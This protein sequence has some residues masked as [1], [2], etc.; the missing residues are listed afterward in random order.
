MPAR[1]TILAILSFM[2]TTQAVAPPGHIM[3]IFPAC[4]SNGV[5]DAVVKLVTDYQT[6]A[7]ATCAGGKK[8][9]FVSSNG[10][11]YTLPVSYPVT[12]G[13]TSKCKFVKAKDAL[14]FTVQVIVGYGAP[15]NRIHQY[16]EHY[17]ISCSFQPAANKKSGSVTVSPGINPA[18]VIPGNSPPRSKSIIHLY[19]VDVIGR[20]LGSA[21]P[22]GK[23]VRLQAVT[24]GLKDKGIRPESCDA[25][26]SKGGRFPVLRSGCGE[27]MVIKRTKGFLTVGKKTYSSFFKLFI[28]NGDPFLSFVCNFTVCDTTCNGSSCSAKAPGRRRRDHSGE[29][30]GTFFWSSKSQA[31]TEVL[32]LTSDPIDVRGGMDQA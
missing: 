16:D 14:V 3:H 8:V 27:G 24:L 11:E 20:K 1:M 25:L 18:K 5:G 19:I 28:V 29:S 4:G 32:T 13:G 17:T 22:A 15:G 23:M 12:G 10:V 7:K 30:T 26:N 6:G 21:A 31:S 9:D 2:A